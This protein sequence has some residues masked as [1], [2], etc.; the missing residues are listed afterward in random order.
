MTGP[1]V[2]MDTQPHPKE[3][4]QFMVRFERYEPVIL[5]HTA[6]ITAKKCLRMYFYQIVLGRVTPDEA[7]YFAWGN[8]YHKFR[9]ML[10]LNY[11]FGDNEPAKYDQEKAIDAFTKAANGGMEYWNKHGQDQQVGTRFGFMTKGRL[12]LSFRAAFKHWEKERQRGQI[13]V[14]ATEQAF[15]VQMPDGTHRSGRADE[16][17]RWTGKLWGRDFKTSSKDSVFFERT[18]DPNEQFTGYTYAESKLSGEPIQG[19]LIEMLFNSNPTKTKENGPEIHEFTASRTS[20]Q[21]MMWE[22]EHMFYKQIIDMAREKDIWPMEEV[23]CSF[24]P[25]HKVC[26]QNSESSQM[27]QLETGYKVRP[28]DNTK[29]G[30]DL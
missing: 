11:G 20:W 3:N 25:Y 4:R 13:K 29:V 10:T 6:I 24:C 26:K 8:A 23:S 15:N 5:D 9:N 22:R 21:L 2:T 30:H 1:I 7:I 17:V 12:L 28:W 16:I 14:L 27:Y 18:I 19:Q